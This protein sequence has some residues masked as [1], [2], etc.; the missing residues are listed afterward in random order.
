MEA[1]LE[2]L[3][4]VFD[5]GLVAVGQAGVEV[6]LERRNE[7]GDELEGARGQRQVARRDGLE[8][9]QRQGAGAQHQLARPRVERLDQLDQPRQQVGRRRRQVADAAAVLEQL[10]HQKHRRAHRRER[11]VA[12][13]QRRPKLLH[14]FP[15]TSRVPVPSKSTF[16]P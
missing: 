5:H 1:D 9:D 15:T 16:L 8:A 2:G 11:L 14:L 4:E 7:A 3:V 13:P 10:P 6:A 12:D